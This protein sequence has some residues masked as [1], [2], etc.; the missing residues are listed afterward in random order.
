MGREVSDQE[1]KDNEKTSRNGPRLVRLTARDK[2]LIAHVTVARYLTGEQ[3]RRLVFSGNTLASQPKESDAGK[4][5]SAVVCRRR[6][7]ALCSE[8]DGPAYLRRLSFR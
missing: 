7:K 3:V 1:A 6:L 8:G 4:Q 2:E 5:S